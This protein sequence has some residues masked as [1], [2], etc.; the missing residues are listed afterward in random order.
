MDIKIMINHFSVKVGKLIFFTIIMLLAKIPFIQ[1]QETKTLYLSGT[2]NEK[3]KTWEFFCTGGRNSNRWTNIQVPSHWEQ[4]GF[5]EYNY[6][7]DY[8]TYGKKFKY[9]DEKG[10]YKYSFK[11]PPD[12]KGKDINIVFEGSM[13]ETEV[14]INGKSVGETHI[15]SFYRFKYN[16]TAFLSYN[17]T[18][19]LEVTVGKMSSNKSVNAAERFADYWI[20][21][22]IFRPV[23]LEAFP[24]EHIQRLAID[25]KADGSFAMDT[26]LDQVAGTTLVRA[27]ISDQKG[28]NLSII[29]KKINAKD[30]L[31]KLTGKLTGIKSWSSETP[32][33]YKVK[34][35]LLKG[36]AVVHTITE[37]FGFRTMEI[38]KG[39]GIY[40]NGTKVKMKGINRHAFW[41]E[42][43]R[44]LNDK[45]NLDDVKLMKEL[46][47]NAVRCSH[48]PP[49]KVF[50]DYCDSL[51]L[52]V[53][54]E[55]AGWQNAYDTQVG[56][57]LVKEMVVRDV[58][59]P[60]IIFWSNG[61]E[62]GHNFALDDDFGL[63]DPSNR[64]VIHAHHR[65]GN[66]FN[67]IDCNH[68]EDYYSSSN[69]LKGPNIYM[70]TEFL[71]GQDDGGMAAGL[72]DFWELFWKEKLSGGGFLWALLDEGIVRTDLNGYVDVNRVN[73]PDGIVGPHREREGSFYAMREIF[74]PVKIDM[75]ELPRGFSGDIPVES[76]FHF[77]N[78]QQCSFKFELVNYKHPADHAMGYDVKYLANI[79]SPNVEPV[80]TGL[81][82][83]N[84]PKEWTNY[85]ALS[86]HAYYPNG[87]EILNWTWQIK[88]NTELL[89]PIVKWEKGEV[90]MIENNDSLELKANDIT[91]V[92][93]KKDGKL[94]GLKN[95]FSLPLLF[96]NGPVL[97]GKGESKFAS[98]N[99]YKTDSGYCVEA[100][101]NGALKYIKWT[102]NP[103]GWVRL[104][105]EYRLEGEQDY[106]GITFDF[107]E[108]NIIGVKWL[109][110]GPYR[111]WK[112]RMQG[113]H[114]N[115]F[116]AMYN[117]TF[118]GASPWIYPEF[119]GYY[120][121]IKWME[122]NTSEG[123]FLVASQEKDLFVRLFE[124]YSLS[125]AENLPRLP[126]G[127]ISFLDGIPP[128]GTK[129][130]TNIYANA[131]KLGPNSEL[132]HFD[133]PVKRSLY[134]YF[135]L[136][137]E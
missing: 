135:G 45:I 55:L 29:E 128:T 109:G 21:G 130:W 112:N 136:T 84:L 95:K 63:Y 104:D 49:D 97:V 19:L 123:K 129:L 67:G 126:S 56:E 57:K 98:L 117:N 90:E 36:K 72:Y 58:N 22:G 101:Y 23:Y 119:K 39:D 12:W 79:I 75:K 83:L 46:N 8:M 40:V 24:K 107:P 4:Q 42:T 66:D 82:R 114:L 25:A 31:V 76:R 91:I 81:L 85:D 5:G 69:I 43:G 88:T 96:T 70:V 134:F 125:A 131:S 32:V 10:L 71:H 27:S 18:N 77:I 41:P 17:S 48:Y 1:S 54:D 100:K 59:H 62:G 60:S 6:G 74:S 53:I 28:N 15:G 33:L 3:T 116:Q 132:N 64:P 118:T 35:E 127:D 89:S 93:D 11:L 122:F 65:P 137:E 47:L 38:R 124:F 37:K 50:L 9:A 86:L 73:A 16:V 92:I 20:F 78:L 105:Y 102:M 106:G 30:S 80:S 133:K 99:H 110:N 2:D 121:D 61:N 13:T 52:Y 111:V 108:S 51:G 34:V 103:S 68:Y 113:G 14:K 26:Y 44:C 7:R 115:V 120:S 87:D 94:C